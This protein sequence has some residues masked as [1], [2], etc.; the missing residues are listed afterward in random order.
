MKFGVEKCVVQ[1]MNK[2]GREATEG[3][4]LDIKKV[5]KR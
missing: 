5:W 4:E 2:G 3:I 1:M